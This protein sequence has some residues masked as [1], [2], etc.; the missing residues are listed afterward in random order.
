LNKIGRKV[1][2]GHFSDSALITEAR[3]LLNNPPLHQLVKGHPITIRQILAEFVT[4]CNGKIVEIPIQ[5]L[6]FL[7]KELSR[8]AEEMS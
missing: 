3:P 1:T 4:S 7:K 6:H 8:W 5:I 2:V